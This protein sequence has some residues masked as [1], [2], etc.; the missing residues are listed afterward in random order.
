MDYVKLVETINAELEANG[1]NTIY[2]L[3]TNNVSI[4]TIEDLMIN[5]TKEYSKLTD[6]EKKGFQVYL[7]TLRSQCKLLSIF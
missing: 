1:I 3:I 7:K 6:K 4:S 2:T 5:N